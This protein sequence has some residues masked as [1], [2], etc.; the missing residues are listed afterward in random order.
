[1]IRWKVMPIFIIHTSLWISVQKQIHWYFAAGVINLICLVPP[2]LSR[3]SEDRTREN[4]I[5]HEWEFIR[6]PTMEQHFLGDILTPGH[7]AYCNKKM[8]A[9]SIWLLDNFTSP[10]CHHGFFPNFTLLVRVKHKP[11]PS[12]PLNDFLDKCWWYLQCHLS[13]YIQSEDRVL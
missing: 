1:M 8:Q 6:N 7:T 11:K 4:K 12:P 13:I 5:Y 9:K 2:P 3:A 10:A